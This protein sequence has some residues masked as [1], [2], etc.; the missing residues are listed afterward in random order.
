MRIDDG[1]KREILARTNIAEYIGQFVTL[2]RT[3]NDDYLG[4][5]PFHGEKSPSFHVHGD[6]GFFK[7]FGCGVGGDVIKFIQLQDNLTFPDALRVLAKRA[8]VEL[9]AE[10]PAAARARSEKE[11]IYHA[12][13]IATAFYHRMLALDPR[14]AQAR[15]YCAARGITAETI[16]AFKL[17]FAPE[18]FDALANELRVQGVAPEVGLAAGLL[19]S[20][21][22]SPYDA[23]R[24]RL[25]IPTYSLTGEVIAFGGRA[26]GEDPPKYL[27]TSTT[28]V[29]TKG[30]FLYAL[31][32]ARRAA[33]KDDAVI[34][35]E[36][37]LDC[38]ALHAAG[39]TNAVAALGTAFTPEQARELRKVASRVYLCF[40]ADAAGR[41]ATAKS[42]DI[43]VKEGVLPWI[44]RVPDGEDPDEFVR[45]QGGE[46]FR[47]LL[48]QATSA[49]QF[50]LDVRID[51]AGKHADR[52]ALARWAEETIQTLVSAEERDRWRAYLA[53]RLDLSIDDLRKSRL[54]TSATH[55]APR[56][57][58]AARHIAPGQVE[59][60]S[61]ERDVLAIV[62]D[63]PALLREFA[64]RIPA[65]RFADPNLRRIYAACIEN[66]EELL[67]PSDVLALFAQDDTATTALSRIVGADRSATVRFKD[68]DE[69]RIHLERVVARFAS[70]DLRRRYSELHAQVN[71]IVEAGERVPADLRDEYANVGKQL[72]G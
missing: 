33:A 9:E 10:N 68:G 56:S 15:A 8:G 44:V 32:I 46:A 31:N 19:K 37:Y 30:R 26:L 53:Q 21:Q 55:F 50:K 17:G 58:E 5:C 20:G 43:L 49:T 7:C 34:V 4:L 63:E 36:G 28:P 12:N 52:T 48:A 11:A 54:V 35:V 66:R 16:A 23:F 41:S 59:A 70:D 1:A 27:N 57:A 61:Y 24:N 42:V 38:I 18:G 67:Q 72:K 40:D 13:E 51:E 60:P 25:M 62:C 71:S 64:A 2:R 39:V 22:R 14:G 29:Y 47:A 6:R 69:R 3:R 65:E 45:R